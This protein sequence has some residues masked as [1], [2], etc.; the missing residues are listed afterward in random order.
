MD[1]H[2]IYNMTFSSIYG[3]L[4]KKVE[5]K[6][7]TQA[8]LDEIIRWMTNYSQEELDNYKTND[9][10]VRE[11]YDNARLNENRHL[12][13]GSICGV[14]IAEI[15]QPLMKEIRYMDKLVDELAKGKAIEKIKR[16]PK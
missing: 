13:T 15:Q 12:I 4:L 10:T 1:Q 16:Q 8:E 7:R 2:R 3:S 11:F 14:K 5:R 6:N 9:R